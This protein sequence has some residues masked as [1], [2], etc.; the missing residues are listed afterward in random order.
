M[1]VENYKVIVKWHSSTNSLLVELIKETKEDDTQWKGFVSTEYIY[2][3]NFRH[4]GTRY[5]EAPGL[6]IVLEK[7]DMKGM[8]LETEEGKARLCKKIL[9]NGI[10]KY[11]DSLT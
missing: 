2:F 11:P 1:K 5:R 3:D 8:N 10:F 4:T 6:E 9:F 7:S